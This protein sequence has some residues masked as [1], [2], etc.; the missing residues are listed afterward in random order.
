VVVDIPYYPTIVFEKLDMIVV[1]FESTR[2]ENGSGDIRIRFYKY[3]Y[4]CGIE[5]LRKYGYEN[6]NIHIRIKF[7]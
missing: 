1:I 5:F 4:K 6:R 3:K 7:C 2:L